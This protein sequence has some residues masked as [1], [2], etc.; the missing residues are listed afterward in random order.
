[1]ELDVGLCCCNFCKALG[2]V[3]GDLILFK[4]EGLTKESSDLGECVDYAD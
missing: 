3:K 4:T 1:M 2:I